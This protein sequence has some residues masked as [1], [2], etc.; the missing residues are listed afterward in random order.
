MPSD[1]AFSALADPV[2]RQVLSVLA[3]RAE[4]SAGELA[5]HIE[6]VGRTAV[7]SQVRILCRA[8]LIAKRKKG[9]FRHY[10][11]NP[12]GPAQDVIE[13]QAVFQNS[14]GTSTKVS[15]EDAALNSAVEETAKAPR[16]A[17]MTL[18]IAKND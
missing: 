11:I 12:A 14:P 18:E 4:C 10:S 15:D 16:S 17:A 7:S 9:R 2:R 6:R 8:G 5:V 13:L 3:E 1:L